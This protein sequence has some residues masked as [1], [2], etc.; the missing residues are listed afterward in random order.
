MHSFLWPSNIALYI[1]VPQLLCS[2]ICQWTS[3]LLPCSSYCKQCCSEQWDTCVFF[4]FGF[5][6]MYARSGIAGSYGGFIPSFLRNLH[7]I[8]HSGCINLHS[9]QQCKSVPLSPHPLQH[10]LF[11]DFLMMAVL[12]GMRWYLIVV[13]ICISLIVSDAEHLFMCLL[14]ICMP[15][16]EKCLLRSFPHFLIGL[17]VLLTLSCMSCLYILEINPLSVVSFAII[18]SHSECCLFTFLQF[19]LL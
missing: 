10:L 6:R 9:H 2:F 13:L 19:P 12:T 18:F 5:L 8:F 7:T 17:F 1:H 3:R 15:Y 11:V 16:L 14:A 4:N